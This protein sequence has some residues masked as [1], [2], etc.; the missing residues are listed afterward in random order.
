[1]ALAV[2]RHSSCQHLS[3]MGLAV[4]TLACWGLEWDWRYYRSGVAFRITKCQCPVGVP[5]A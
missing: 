3:Q 5:S 2:G 1:M 4:L